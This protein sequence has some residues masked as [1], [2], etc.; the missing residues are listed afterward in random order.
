[1]GNQCCSDRTAEAENKFMSTSNDMQTT[2][3]DEP[4]PSFARLVNQHIDLHPK[5]K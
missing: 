5:V 4:L 3:T 1:M 2:E